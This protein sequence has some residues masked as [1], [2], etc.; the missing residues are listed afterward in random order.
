MWSSHTNKRKRILPETSRNALLHSEERSLRHR[1]DTKDKGV[2]S[3]GGYHTTKTRIHFNMKITGR[4]QDKETERTQAFDCIF[5]LLHQH[6]LKLTSP[7]DFLYELITCLK[8]VWHVSY[9]C[10]KHLNLC[11][12]IPWSGSPSMQIGPEVTPQSPTAPEWQEISSRW[13]LQT[14]RNLA[15]RRLVDW[16]GPC[17]LK[18]RQSSMTM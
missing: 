3:A 15:E 6:T 9:Y 17:S 7:L 18:R 16:E 2:I 13:Y 10:R 14:L 12:E 8:A 1:L 4:G 11:S 5:K